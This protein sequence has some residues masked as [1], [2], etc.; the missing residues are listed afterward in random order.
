MAGDA[1][2]RSRSSK[3][4]RRSRY[5]RIGCADLFAANAP[6]ETG[7]NQPVAC[8]DRVASG[9]ATILEERREHCQATDSRRIRKLDSCDGSHINESWRG[10]PESPLDSERKECQQTVRPRRRLLVLPRPADGQFRCGMRTDGIGSQPV[11]DPD[12][13]NV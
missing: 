13:G 4:C 2:D 8:A 1:G 5:F 6:K 9:T 3:I 7:W 10:V 12:G 11:P